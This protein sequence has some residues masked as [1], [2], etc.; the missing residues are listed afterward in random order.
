MA[1]VSFF[2]IHGFVLWAVW[3]FFGLFQVTTNRY[4]KHHW[5]A[6]MWLHRVSGSVVL[7]TTLLYGVVGFAKLMMVKDD[8][9]APM[10]IAVTCIVLFLTMSGVY[11]RSRLVRAEQDQQKMLRAKWC[12]KIFA[13]IMLVM[14]QITIFFG[15]YSYTHNRDIDTVLHYLSIGLFV[16]LLGA[17][18]LWHQ[19]FLGKDPIRFNEPLNT[20]SGEEFDMEV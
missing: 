9:H 1:K 10:G 13:Y 14:T 3:T 12:H 7:F 2:L 16:V 5:K 17:L 18:E 19:R 11:A 20:M 8:V 15:I 4:M 6:N